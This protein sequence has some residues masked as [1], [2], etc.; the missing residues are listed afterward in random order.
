M[1]LHAKFNSRKRKIV[2]NF[3][4]KE[5]EEHRKKNPERKAKM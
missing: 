1:T 5:M 2:V 4:G 3:H